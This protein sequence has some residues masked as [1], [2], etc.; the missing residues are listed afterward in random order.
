[1]SHHLRDRMQPAGMIPACKSILWAH[2]T[3]TMVAL[4]K[5]DLLKARPMSASEKGG[6]DKRHQTFDQLGWA[7]FAKVVRTPGREP[8]AGLL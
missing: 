2:G 8:A 4:A 7:R 5:R 6:E 3:V 1:M